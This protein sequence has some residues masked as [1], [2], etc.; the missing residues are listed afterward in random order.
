MKKI[1]KIILALV[2]IFSL[3][4]NMNAYAGTI[5]TN[6]GL[7]VSTKESL[8]E[9]LYFA[10]LDADSLGISQTDFDKLY[11]GDPFY[12]YECIG[13]SLQELDVLTYPIFCDNKIVLFC[14]ENTKDE[15]YFVQLSNGFTEELT[16]FFISETE[17]ALVYDNEKCYI[18]SENGIE[19]LSSAG[20]QLDYRDR[21]DE[22]QQENIIFSKLQPMEKVEY[23]G[24]KTRASHAYLSIPLVLQ[25]DYNICWAASVAS[26]GNY[27]ASK[28]YTAIDIAKSYYGDDFNYG[29]E[30]NTAMDVLDKVYGTKYYS[31]KTE[32][33]SDSMIYYNLMAGYP[34]YAKWMS[35][36]NSH[37]TVI[38]GIMT[39]SYMQIMD[40]N[41]GF[42]VV[43]KSGDTY[44]YY[45]N[46]LGITWTYSGHGARYQYDGQ[47]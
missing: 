33:L 12:S 5:E 31:S 37:A 28:N 9:Q 41:S 35:G 16:N 42:V 24:I 46:T 27:I 6:N 4:N 21:L 38:R 13:G 19:T 15:E 20:V 1:R 10:Y 8:N 17:I 44:S 2:L 3:C 32:T 34:V 43:N 14:V 36:Y 22:C 18:V 47:P 23:T 39:D 7:S 11:I 40:P 45:C 30:V 29:L 25:G 26:I